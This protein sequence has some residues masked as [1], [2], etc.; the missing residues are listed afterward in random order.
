[1]TGQISDMFLYEGAEYKLIGCDAPFVTPHLFGMKTKM[2]HTAC[3]RG[4]ICTFEIA[5]GHILLRK[6]I[7]RELNANYLPIG[8]VEPSFDDRRTTATY[9]NLGVPITYSGTLRIA[10]GLIPSLRI[11]M[12]HQKASAF[13]TVLDIEV[14]EGRITEVRDRSAEALARRGEFAKRY[15]RGCEYGIEDAFDLD[16]EHW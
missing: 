3:Y 13:E 10:N 2:L 15:A 5:N 4:Y 14:S 6:M 12:G 7:M 1:M 8:G 9:D 16:L 11:H